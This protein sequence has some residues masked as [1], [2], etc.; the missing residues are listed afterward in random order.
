MRLPYNSQGVTASQ[1]SF[2]DGCPGRRSLVLGF[3]IHS[4]QKS[5]AQNFLCSCFPDSSVQIRVHPWHFIRELFVGA[6]CVMR[7]ASP[8]FRERMKVRGRLFGLAKSSF[9]A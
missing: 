2:V 9:G 5:V 4:V 1:P 3:L 7:F 8:H 6:Y